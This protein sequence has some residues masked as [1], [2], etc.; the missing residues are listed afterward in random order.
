[1]HP[2]SSFQSNTE[3]LLAELGRLDFGL[4]LAIKLARGH[5]FDELPTEF[6]GLLVTDADVDAI[7]SDLPV[8]KPAKP[9]GDDRLTNAIALLQTQIESRV[10][11]T[12]PTGVI[13][14]L[15]YLRDLF[16]LDELEVDALVLCLAQ[17]IDVKYRNLFAYAHND[18]TKKSPT[19][20]L[21]LDL[22]FDSPSERI[23]H[24]QIFR[25]DSNLVSNNLITVE[26]DRTS[27]GSSSLLSVLRLNPRVKDFL[28]GIDQL[29]PAVAEIAQLVT[30]S[31]GWDELKLEPA[32]LAKL[33]RQVQGASD[34]AFENAS[35]IFQLVGDMGAGK[36]TV[37][38]AIA[39]ALGKNLILMDSAGLSKANSSLD[40][41]VRSV[42]LEAALQNAVICMNNFGS[43]LGDQTAHVE[44]RRRLVEGRLTHCGV[45]IL[46]TDV[47]W[48]DREAHDEQ[49]MFTIELDRQ[50]YSKRKD[51]W[52]TM[53]GKHAND[54]SDSQVSDIASKFKF[55]AGQIKQVIST[56]RDMAIWR[57]S[58]DPVIT[59][60]DL[61]FA[62][63]WHS[64]QA[65]GNLA[66]KLRSDYRWE[67]I[68]LPE[69]QKARLKEICA[70]FR[71]MARVYE[72]WRFQAKTELGKGLNI[73]FAG[74][75]GT[76][77]T[78]AA[79]I[80]SNELFLDIYKIDLSSVVSKYIGETEK[81]LDR[82]FRAAED[83]NAILFFDEADAL[84]GK[85][86]EV[87]DSHDRYANIE[88][89][90][91]LQ[92]MEEYQGITILATN[93]RK[94]LDDAFTRRMH[95][96]VDFPFPEAEFRGEIWRRVFP[97]EAPQ[98]DDTD[99]EY[100][101]QTFKLSGGNIK[102]IAVASAFLAAEENSRI[103]NRH[104]A[105]ATKREH[106]KMGK[107]LIESDLGPYRDPVK[108]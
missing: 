90:Y 13:L 69:D 47:P 78:M 96:I 3:H 26:E 84:F 101:A 30:C 86:S 39:R 54:V 35:L 64:S 20:N 4:A 60:E 107:L 48:R 55:N 19:V 57:D 66:Q 75:S 62:S 24:M 74:A 52:T 80:M 40:Q 92:K 7:L 104:I 33:E 67:D 98:E 70:Y 43:I 32:L 87:R 88:T 97:E 9:E 28:L 106:Q 27:S 18:L 16:K 82:I 31:L 22:M 65:L 71:N 37:A 44:A 36:K 59:T 83:S 99:L 15:P 42:F 17:E 95:F 61:S 38:S 5:N 91:L 10:E 49:V 21:A 29:E 56:A 41:S 53:I 72:D 73:L 46:A 58:I 102:N 77:K 51:L 2:S 23:E 79:Q 85:R 103:G 89:S 50:P 34:R 81:N 76:G 12:R 1:M 45:L 14:R 93:F 11:A 105:K 63:R 100:F 108:V 25:S 6:R 8:V 68:V 94:N